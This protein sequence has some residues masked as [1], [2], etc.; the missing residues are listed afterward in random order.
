MEALHRNFESNMSVLKKL[1]MSL[2]VIAVLSLVMGGLGFSSVSAERGVDIAVVDDEH[3]F[4]GYQSEDC[5]GVESGE[6]ITLVNVTNRFHTDVDVENVE[7][8]SNNPDV[9]FKSPT[10]PREIE[11]GDSGIIEAEVDTC[12][13]TSSAKVTATITVVGN[14]I[15]ATIFGEGETVDREFLVECK[16]PEDEVT[17]RSAKNA[18]Y[19]AEEEAKINVTY[20]FENDGSASNVNV[21]AERKDPLKKLLKKQADINGNYEIIGVEIHGTYFPNPYV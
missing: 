20:K 19:W 15:N 6:N 12:R 10:K 4:V 21:T 13:P 1:S 9:S 16:A 17:F 5:E 14:G 11:P 3:A 7:V 8:T 2:A 18:H